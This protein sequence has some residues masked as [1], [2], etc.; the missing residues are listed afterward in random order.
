M[1][2]I[3]RWAAG[4]ADKVRV[5][6]ARRFHPRVARHKR[7]VGTLSI[8]FDDFPRTAWTEGG[9]ILRGHE[10]RATY[11][12]CGAL[13]ATV[14]DG[15][16]MFQASD[17][18]AIHAAGHELGC[19]TFTHASCLRGST[20]DL[21]RS[22]HDNDAFVRREV[23]DVRLRSFAYPYGD[24]SVTT[25]RFLIDHFACIRGVEA[26]INV[27]QLDLGQLKA[28]GLEVGKRTFDEVKDY[29][30][31]AA[32]CRGWVI[33]FTHDVQDRPSRYGCRPDDLDRL[34]RLAKAGGLRVLP[35]N[36]ALSAFTSEAP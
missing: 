23:G 13:C 5:A 21:D 8:C 28:V 15:E 7:T 31:H 14:F 24:A 34:L 17:L 32:A 36:A 3:M 33:V 35:V 9:R 12:V 16:A 27:D 11:Y 20:A 30:L 22:I 18:R 10:V 6:M 2:P 1:H 29:L 25:K 26:G 4:R 19:H